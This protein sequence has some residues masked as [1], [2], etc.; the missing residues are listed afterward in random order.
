VRE[1]EAALK[2]L[3]F[4]KI[5]PLVHTAPEGPSFW[6]Q[7]SGVPRRTFPVF[8]GVRAEE[9]A[10]KLRQWLAQPRDPAPPSRRAILVVPTDHVAEEAWA[11]WPSVLG[12]DPELAILVVPPVPGGPSDSPHWHSRV[13]DRRELLT[14]TTGIV[15]GLFRLS[16]ETEG[17]GQLD[18]EEMLDLLRSRFGVDVQASLGVSSDPDA[19]F[20]L[21][22]LAQRDAYAPGEPA[23]N[24][25]ALVL[26]PTGPAARLPWFAG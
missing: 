12:D 25:H 9:S 11:R 19:L 6:V 15:V 14:L 26:K 10:P 3:G 18:F 4:A 13:V 8:I 1:A 24:L 22:Q 7:E 23:S 21:Y 16:Q 5:P 2:R 20:L 17:S